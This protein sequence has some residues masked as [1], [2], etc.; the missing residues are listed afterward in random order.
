MSD[1]APP[2]RAE[3]E[4]EQIMADVA[5]KRAQ[6]QWEPWKAMATVL[7]ASAAIFTGLGV[8][9]GYLLRGTVH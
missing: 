1:W 6:T 7:G 9:I 5:L 4:V 3:L 2:S 8:L